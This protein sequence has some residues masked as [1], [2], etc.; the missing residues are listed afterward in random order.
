MAI[1]SFQYL[2]ILKSPTAF[3]EG[4]ISMKHVDAMF[5]K[6]CDLILFRQRM[7]PV[8]FSLLNNLFS[9]WIF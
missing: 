2:K 3:H 4:S 9:E 1:K 8:W 7:I 5:K 6:I